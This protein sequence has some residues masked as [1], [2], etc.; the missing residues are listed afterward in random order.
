M[1]T[2]VEAA[3][4]N[5]DSADT[6]SWYDL[7]VG[8]PSV[9]QRESYVEL[10]VSSRL[11][12]LGVVGIEEWHVANGL[13][14]T[15]HQYDPD[16]ALET[17]THIETELTPNAVGA[18]IRGEYRDVTQLSEAPGPLRTPAQAPSFET[19]CPIIVRTEGEV[20]FATFGRFDDL[21]VVVTVD[22]ERQPDHIGQADEE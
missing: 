15:S 1:D 12:D 9:E 7:M 11:E 14:F 17:V 5:S 3:T 13:R 8:A 19:S 6:P 2:P 10:A 20:S 4:T 22:E 18:Y 16:R 21:H